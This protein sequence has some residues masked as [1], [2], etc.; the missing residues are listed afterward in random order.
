MADVNQL[1]L[2]TIRVAGAALAYPQITDVPDIAGGWRPGR[3]R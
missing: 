2:T 1:N 3:I